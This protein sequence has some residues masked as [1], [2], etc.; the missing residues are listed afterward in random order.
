MRVEVKKKMAVTNKLRMSH[1][2][3]EARDSEAR[4]EKWEFKM[5]IFVF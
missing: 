4:K 3:W 1:Q 2:E 5:V